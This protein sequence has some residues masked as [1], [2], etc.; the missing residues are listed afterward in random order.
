MDTKIQYAVG[1]Q[2]RTPYAHFVNVAVEI[3]T[4]FVLGNGSPGLTA[5]SIFYQ[6]GFLIALRN[7]VL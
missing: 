4:E 1:S 5:F 7:D 6:A 2:H 3:F